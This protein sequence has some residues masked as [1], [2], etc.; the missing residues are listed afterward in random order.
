MKKRRSIFHIAFLIFF[1]LAPLIL[2]AAD[3]VSEFN[4]ANKL[5]EQQKFSEAAAAYEKLISEGVSSGP[6]YFNLGNAFFK[7]GE[8]GRAIAAYRTAEKLSPRDAE[9]RAYLK[10]ARAQVQTGN[11]SAETSI[12]QLLHWLTLNEWTVLTATFLGIFFLLLAVGQISNSVRRTVRV[13]AICAGILTLIFGVCT[14]FAAQQHFKKSAVVA[15]SEAV[16][17]RGPFAESQSAFTLRDGAEITVENEREKWLQIS[18]AANR[19]GWIS[20]K[21]VVFVR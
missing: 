19:T 15:V 8:L 18:D 2:S 13:Y 6:L 3:V 11:A 21:Q 5:Y 16:V 17:R 12:T 10:F 9:I 14:G 7:S 1:L 4:R 20:E